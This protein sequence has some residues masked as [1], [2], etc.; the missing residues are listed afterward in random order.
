M[1]ERKFGHFDSAEFTDRYEEAIA[2]MVPAKQVGSKARPAKAA[3]S[4]GNVI[5]LM[6]ALRRSPG[7]SAISAAI[8]AAHCGRKATGLSARPGNQICRGTRRRD[9]IAEGH[10]ADRRKRGGLE[11]V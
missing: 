1:P 11:T 4:S 8:Q 2:E 7:S 9:V 10:P 6:E 5:N 3:P